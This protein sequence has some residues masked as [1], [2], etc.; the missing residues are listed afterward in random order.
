M[1]LAEATK[2]AL[3]LRHLTNSFGMPQLAPTVI[4]C[5]SQSAIAL[6]KN[7]ARQHDRSKHIDIR[8]HFI[9]EQSD[10][11]YEHIESANNLA[12][13]LTKSLGA[14]QFKNFTDRLRGRVE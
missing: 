2:E 8:Y 7:N 12:D 13:I 11:I 3:H 1:A 6:S 9:R 10:V 14:E 4:F 5:D